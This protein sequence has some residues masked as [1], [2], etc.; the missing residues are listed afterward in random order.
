MVGGWDWG[1][2][3]WK[4]GGLNEVR[5]GDP[6]LESY[7]TCFWL[8]MMGWGLRSLLVR[9]ADGSCWLEMAH[10]VVGGEWW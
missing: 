1:T 10:V 3:R 4:V 9:Q 8:Q 6:G 5:N 2:S 7:G